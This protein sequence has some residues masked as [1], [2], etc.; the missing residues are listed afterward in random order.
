[1]GGNDPRRARERPEWV[2]GGTV[3]PKPGSFPPTQRP[4]R[5]PG[6][7]PSSFELRCRSSVLGAS[8]PRTPPRTGPKTRAR[9]WPA[10][11]GS[12]GAQTG[13]ATARQSDRRASSHVSEVRCETSPKRA[14][15]RAVPEPFRYPKPR[16]P[17]RARR[18]IAL[19]FRGRK[20]LPSHHA[21]ARVGRDRMPRIRGFRTAFVVRS[22]SEDREC[23]C[24]RDSPGAVE[25]RN[26]LEER[27]E[28]RRNAGSM[29]RRRRA[30]RSASDAK[31]GLYSSMN[32]SKRASVTR[33]SSTN[34]NVMA[35]LAVSSLRR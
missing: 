15:R 3:R 14:R 9:R 31:S 4:R 16:L 24:R 30:R 19:R 17:S 7:G 27:R 13:R 33:P 34:V 6:F 1:M 20:M 26:A 11:I 12:L 22:R 28:P 8:D 5:P 21:A 25:S 10:Q 2:L 35:A 18:C 32:R 23:D 29:Q